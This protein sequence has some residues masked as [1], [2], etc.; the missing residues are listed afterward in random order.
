MH[1]D[2]DGEGR[3]K[4]GWRRWRRSDRKGKE[5]VG[6][7][8]KDRGC[9][10]GRARNGRVEKARRRSDKKGTESVAWKVK[11]G[12]WGSEG[13]GRGGGRRIAKERTGE[14]GRQPLLVIKTEI[15]CDVTNNCL[16]KDDHWPI[17]DNL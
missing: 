9:M 17:P 7:K 1:G 10:Q 3:G 12:V 16:M 13:R 4:G 2:G 8:V 14:D 6:W 11:D 15:Y 5:S